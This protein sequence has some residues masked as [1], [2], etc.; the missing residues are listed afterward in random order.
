MQESFYRH[1]ASGWIETCEAGDREEDQMRES[2]E[3]YGV[4]ICTTSFR[5][6]GFIPRN[7]WSAISTMIIYHA[8]AIAHGDVRG[9]LKT[10]ICARSRRVRLEQLFYQPQREIRHTAMITVR[11]WLELINR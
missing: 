1:F 3:L 9:W 5:S 8:S 7:G 4:G 10:P 2:D 6:I 11:V